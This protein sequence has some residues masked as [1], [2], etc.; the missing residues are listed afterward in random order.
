MTEYKELYFPIYFNWLEM[1]EELSDTE[2][3]I[4]VRA[5]LENF[6][7]RKVPKNLSDKM[8]II[9]KFMLDS[10]AR[11]HQGQR[12]LSEKRRES[13][14]KRW[15]KRENTEEICNANACK[16]MQTDAIN[17]NEKENEKENENVNGNGNEKENGNKNKRFAREAKKERYGDFDANEAFE[18]ALLRTYGKT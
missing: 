5:L 2:L 13:A 8:R 1:T 11:T 4:L 7:E 6:S 15:A 14:N 3:G 18:K 9:Y 17:E 16:P 12:E 10:G